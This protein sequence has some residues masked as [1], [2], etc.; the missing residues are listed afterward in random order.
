MSDPSATTPANPFA[1]GDP[2]DDGLETLLRETRSASLA[3]R[4]AAKLADWLLWTAAVLGPILLGLAINGSQ[5]HTGQTEDAVLLASMLTA[6]VVWVGLVAAQWWL[7]ATR[8]QSLGKRFM[9]VRVIRT[10][11][12]D[13]GFLDGVVL[14]EIVPGAAVFFLNVCYLGFL[15][16]LVDFAA[17]YVDAD[18]RTLHDRLAHT[19]VVPASPRVR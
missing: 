15:L 2:L 5:G 17:A 8:G 14:R 19:R 18:Q 12:G 10:D 4:G 1:T 13:V 9:G 11:G 16:R 3:A 7:I 6:G